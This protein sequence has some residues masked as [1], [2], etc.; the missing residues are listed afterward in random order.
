[1]DL[2]LAAASEWAVAIGLDRL[3]LDVH[4]DNHRAQGAYRRSGFEPTGEELT[5][6]IGPEIVMVRPLSALG[7]ARQQAGGLGRSPIE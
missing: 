6:P 5:G 2:L 7:G 1:M 4:R 3:H